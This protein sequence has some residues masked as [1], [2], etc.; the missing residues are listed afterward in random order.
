MELVTVYWRPVIQWVL[1]SSLLAASFAAEAAGH[2]TV[3]W[4]LDGAAVAVYLAFRL[5]AAAA[6]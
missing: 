5:V 6:R 2:A 4:A 3:S 1:I